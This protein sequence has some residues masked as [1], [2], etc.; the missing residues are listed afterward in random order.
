MD[1]AKEIVQ[2]EKRLQYLATELSTKNL[3]ADKLEEA[4]THLQTYALLLSR[5]SKSSSP[6]DTEETFGRIRDLDRQLTSIENMARLAT[7]KASTEGVLT[8]IS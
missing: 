1:L 5:L 3:S 6:A 4:Q 7:A 8:T 2:R